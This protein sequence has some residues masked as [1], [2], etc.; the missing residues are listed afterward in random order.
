MALTEGPSA[1][2]AAH[3]HML[4]PPLTLLLLHLPPPFVSC[5]AAAR[6][7]A[8]LLLLLPS[9]VSC[10]AAAHPA[11]APSISCPTLTAAVLALPAAPP[12][13]LRMLTA[14]IL[15]QLRAHCC[16]ICSLLPLLRCCSYV[17][18]GAAAAGL[19]VVVYF[20]LKVGVGLVQGGM[21]VDMWGAAG[22]PAHVA[23]SDASYQPAPPCPR[24]RA[25]HLATCCMRRAAA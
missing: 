9:F 1:A 8:A 5:L 16:H 10:L 25:G 7:A 20:R 6:P 3:P 22:G 12:I 4:P 24:C 21:P 11:A 18:Y 23:V 15:A 13:S 19:G 17:L 2:R 14:A